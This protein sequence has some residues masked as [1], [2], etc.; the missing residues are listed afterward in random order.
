MNALANYNNSLALQEYLHQK[1]MNQA[2][3]QLADACIQQ[4][5]NEWK[6]DAKGFRSDSGS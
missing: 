1:Q 4:K 2:Y 3:L 6:K 5:E